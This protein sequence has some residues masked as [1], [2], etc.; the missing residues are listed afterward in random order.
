MKIEKLDPKELRKLSVKDLQRKLKDLKLV[1][2]KLR[3]KQQIDGT[4]ENPM[5][6][7]ITKRNI[8]RILTIIREKQLKGEN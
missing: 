6:I 2:M 1:L 3:M 8:A 4:L 5:A 7:R